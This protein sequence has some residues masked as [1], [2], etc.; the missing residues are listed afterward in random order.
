MTKEL[1]EEEDKSLEEPI[2]EKEFNTEFFESSED[3]QANMTQEQPDVPPQNDPIRE[4]SQPHLT[5]VSDN[6]GDISRA[7]R[8][9]ADFRWFGCNA[10]HLN[11]IAQVAFKKVPVAARLVKRAKKL[12]EFIRKS[13]TASNLLGEYNELLN[14]TPSKLHQENATRWWSI[15]IMFKSL[16]RNAH[17]LTLTLFRLKRSKMMLNM[18]EMQAIRRIVR[19]LGPFK[20]IADNLGSENMITG[21]LI[22]P[23]FWRLREDILEPQDRDTPMIRDMRRVMLAKYQTRHTWAQKRFFSAM[24]TLDVR[25]KLH[26]CL[27]ND[28]VVENMGERLIKA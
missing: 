2:D 21:S 4:Y 10:H 6:A 17:A 15:L 18:A 1:T 14:E 20:E 28:P 25:S 26:P 27:K 8:D 22:L 7:I 16:L 12:V 9:L 23:F 19:L 11:L 13:T 24:T 5:I 3:L